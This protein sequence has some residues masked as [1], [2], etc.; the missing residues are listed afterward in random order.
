MNATLDTSSVNALPPVILASA[1]P[2]R[3]RLLEELGIDFQVIPG[4]T[5]EAQPEHLTPVEACLLNAYHK[6]RALA[7]K[8]PDALVIGAD[9]EVCLCGKVFGKPATRE[10]ARRMLTELEGREHQV[11][12]GVCMIHLRHHKQRLF[13]EQTC[14]KFRHLGADE[15]DA[16]LDKIDPLDKAGAYGIQDHG[17]LIV[18]QL[19]GSFSNVVGLPLEKLKT[20]LHRFEE[21]VA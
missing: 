6:A 17:D 8:E 20:E 1:S 10:A 21:T 2:R 4:H 13:A 16:Y 14:V 7:K 11:I 18:E 5:P 9:T 3:A 12:T 15:I 19:R